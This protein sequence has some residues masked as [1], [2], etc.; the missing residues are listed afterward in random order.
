[1]LNRR[2]KGLFIS[3]SQQK[4]RLDSLHF[5]RSSNSSHISVCCRIL[6]SPPIARVSFSSLKSQLV[7]LLKMPHYSLLFDRCP[8][9]AIWWALIS[10][11]LYRCN[12][13]RRRRRLPATVPNCN[14]T[15]FTSS[16]AAIPINAAPANGRKC[17]FDR[18]CKYTCVRA[19]NQ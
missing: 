16:A 18:C 19:P 17:D 15:G 3:I 11:A 10:F 1:M 2:Q 13:S 14:Q 4:N 7:P 8:L 9:Y 5:A 6:F 12:V